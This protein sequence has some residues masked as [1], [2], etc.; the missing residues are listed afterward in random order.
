MDYWFGSYL[1]VVSE[2]EKSVECGVW[3]YFW[4]VY[5]CGCCVGVCDVVLWCRSFGIIGRVWY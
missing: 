2:I 5:F 1:V 3:F 4:F